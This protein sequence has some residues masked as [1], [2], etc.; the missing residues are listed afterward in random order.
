MVP[1]SFWRELRRAGVEV[2]VVNLP[3]LSSPLRVFER[4]H[5][6]LLAVDGRYASTG[7]VR[8][9]DLWLERSS[10]MGL[11]Y[12]DT[13]VGVWGPAV[14]DLERTFAGVWELSGVPLPREEL[15]VAEDIP[16]AGE[17]DVRVIVQEPGKMRVLGTLD[18]LTSAVEERM[19]IA[20]A[21]FLSAPTLTQ[22]LMSAL[23]DV[24]DVR[25]LVPTPATNDQPP[26]GTLSRAGYRQ[27]LEAG[28]RIFEYGGPMMHAK[29]IVD[30]GSG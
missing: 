25:I 12:R 18:L 3:A 28:V 13:S 30:L 6:K 19:W 27:L 9:A 23:R 11:P 21:Y 1:R 2:R 5:R 7:G 10:E 15:S 26:V 20:D 29:T 4:D 17:Q 22:A 14:A 24:V 16:K 8:V